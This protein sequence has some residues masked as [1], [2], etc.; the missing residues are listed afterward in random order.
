MGQALFWFKT[1]PCWLVGSLSLE[2]VVDLDLKM[3][4]LQNKP[5]DFI[6]TYTSITAGAS[7]SSDT[8]YE[9][10]FKMIES[11]IIAPVLMKST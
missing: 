1:C 3:V 8:I 7:A 6:G 4:D 5:T 11:G 9:D 2:K 10:G